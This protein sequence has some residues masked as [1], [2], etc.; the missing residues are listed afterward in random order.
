MAWH[1]ID[2]KP[3]PGPMMSQFTDAYMHDPTS[4][5]SLLYLDYDF[6]WILIEYHIPW[7]V[8][9]DTFDLELSVIFFLKLIQ[10]DIFF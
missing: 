10:Y 6:D 7:V 5:W 3:L 9:N 4:M 8:I 2:D 1:R